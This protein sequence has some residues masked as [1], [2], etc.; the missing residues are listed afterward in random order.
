M[1]PEK[2]YAERSGSGPYKSNLVATEDFCHL[3]RKAGLGIC[4]TY[5]HL[6]MVGGFQSGHEMLPGYI[7]IFH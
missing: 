2:A 7:A 3:R 4:S 6:S 5:L 1:K